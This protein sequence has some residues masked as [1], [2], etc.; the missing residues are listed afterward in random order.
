MIKRIGLKNMNAEI[1]KEKKTVLLAC[2]HQGGAYAG[3]MKTLREVSALFEPKVKVCVVHQ[4]FLK[5][6][7]E[8]FNIG[9][10]PTFLMLATGSERDRMLGE[11][12]RDA[13]AVFILKNLK[14][15]KKIISPSG[16]NR[17]PPRPFV[18]RRPRT[19]RDTSLKNRNR[20]KPVGTG[21]ILKGT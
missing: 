2:V 16:K 20:G 15:G 1:I 8:R 7:C 18:E 4:H 13:L 14:Q 10:T 9:G 12:D 5:G 21:L 6:V 19:G 3:L 11:A 17:E